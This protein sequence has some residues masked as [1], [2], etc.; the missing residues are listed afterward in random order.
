MRH[1][2]E[3]CKVG[4]SMQCYHSQQF[5]VQNCAMIFGTKPSLTITYVVLRAR[6][7]TLTVD[8]LSILVS[9]HFFPLPNF[10]GIKED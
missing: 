3:H 10:H 1:N 9:N 4:P 5:W 8:C 2:L 7:S 6:I